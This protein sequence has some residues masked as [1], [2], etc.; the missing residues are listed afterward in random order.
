M[1]TI[2]WWLSTGD[3]RKLGATCNINSKPPVNYMDASESPL[4]LT[5]FAELLAFFAGGGEGPVIN[6]S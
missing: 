1:K 2:L 3:F 4:T 6:V 5:S